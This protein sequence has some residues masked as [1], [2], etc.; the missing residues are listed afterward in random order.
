MAGISTSLGHIEVEHDDDGAIALVLYKPGNRNADPTD[1]DN[2]NNASIDAGVQHEVQRWNNP[3]F[4]PVGATLDDYPVGRD[5]LVTSTVEGL[6]ATSDAN[7]IRYFL[8]QFTPEDVE[9]LRPL[10]EAG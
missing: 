2:P 5:G 10:I 1:P 6:P 7:T 8:E 3:D 4:G 9:A